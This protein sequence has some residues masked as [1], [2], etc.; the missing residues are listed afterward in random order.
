MPPSYVPNILRLEEDLSNLR[1][2]NSGCSDSLRLVI[3]WGWMKIYLQKQRNRWNIW[4][5]VGG[6]E[7]QYLQIDASRVPDKR[8]CYVKRVWLLRI[9]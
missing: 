1:F 2:R 7:S 5:M 8:C 4:R 3:R 9:Q 6:K